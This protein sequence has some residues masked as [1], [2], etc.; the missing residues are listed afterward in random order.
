MCDEFTH[1]IFRTLIARTLTSKFRNHNGVECFKTA[2]ESSI[3]VLVDATIKWIQDLARVASRRTSRCG[4]TETNAVDLFSALFESGLSFQELVKF[5]NDFSLLAIQPYEYLISPYPVFSTS[6]YYSDQFH[7]LKY[8]FQRTNSQG[9]GQYMTQ[10]N[11]PAMPPNPQMG[12]NIQGHPSQNINNRAIP[13]PTMQGQQMGQAVNQHDYRLPFRANT[14]ISYFPNFNNNSNIS[15]TNPNQHP[16]VNINTHGLPSVSTVSVAGISTPPSM[17]GNPS[18]PN[19]AINGLNDENGNG[20]DDESAL[21]QYGDSIPSFFPELPPLFT[22]KEQK[23]TDISQDEKNKLEASRENDQRESKE[24]LSKLVLN[25]SQLD[26]QANNKIFELNLVKPPEIDRPLGEWQS[27]N[28]SGIYQMLGERNG[29]NPEFLPSD[30]DDEIINSAGPNNKEIR[31][32]INILKT[33]HK[34][35]ESKTD[36]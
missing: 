23:M 10:G 15:N 31:F 35:N 12:P 22:Y 3:D 1:K 21:D 4:R 19:V 29:K 2:S 25:K 30:D 7:V 9:A 14:T 6:K 24:G 27:E 32:L 33:T 8:K 34:G 11:H 17:V 16:T 20:E 28:K 13:N 36:D 5:Y 26:E 18:M